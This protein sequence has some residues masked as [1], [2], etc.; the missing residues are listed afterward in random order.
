MDNTSRRELLRL[1]GLASLGASLGRTQSPGAKSVADMP[2]QP[3]E[4]IRI[5][6][7]GTG[8]RGNALVDNFS[9]VP[10][11]RIT[12]QCDTAKDKALKTQTKFDKAGKASHPLALFHSDDH[13]FEGLLKRHD[14][15]L[16]VIDTPRSW[17]VPMAV[18]GMKQGK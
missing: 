1:A 14:T 7:I 10:G 4:T 11:V 9:E 17:H 2:F 18:A 16:M 6:V 8:A 15:S 3:T 5:G 12:T 13:A